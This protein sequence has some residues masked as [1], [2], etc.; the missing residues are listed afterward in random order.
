MSDFMLTGR[1][2][3][4]QAKATA[5]DFR[6]GRLS[7]REFFATMAAF[8]VS[9]AG[10]YAL[11]GIRPAAAQDATPVKGGTLRV[12][13]L[14]KA[15]R[16]P[17]IFE[18]TE[19]ANIA[20][21]CNDYLVRW[22]NDFSFAPQLLESWEASDDAMTYTFNVRKGVKWSNGD[23]F[24]A[25]DVIFNLTRW[26]DPSVEGNSFVARLAA[27]MDA[28]GKTLLP[29]A[30]ERV[31]DHTVRLNLRQPDIALIANLS[32]YPALIMHRS[33]DGSDDPMQAL[34][35]GTG[36]FE[37]VSFETGMRAEVR[38]RAQPWWGG[39]V[40][41]DGVVWTDYGTDSTAMVS[42]FAAGEI[43]A[44]YQT[45]PDFLPLVEAAGI[46]TEGAATAQT[47]VLRLNQGVA[48]YDDVR[49]RRAMQLAV[50][51]QKVLELGYGNAGTVAANHHV[52][53]MHE[54]YAD[55]GPA[56]TDGQEA[57]ALMEAAGQADHEFDLISQEEE[58]QSNS[59]DAV[60]DQMRAAGLKVKRTRIPGATFWN[61]WDKYPFSATEWAGRPLGVQVYM[62]AYKST[63]PWSETAFSNA[64]FDALLDE[65]TAI[66]DARKRSEVMAKLQWIMIDEGVILQPYWRS[67]YRS[68]SP[69]VRGLGAHQAFR[70]FMDRVWLTT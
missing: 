31:D 14:V 45:T 68:F 13:M 34:A 30:I 57:A 20:A 60:A 7:R 24:T 44:N 2:L 67:V 25:D 40:H 4:P 47:L 42:A 66:A 56:V 69:R 18:W 22:D 36:P 59:C 16:D 41:L 17:R 64:E 12:A 3:H 70:Q 28:D 55:I 53:P 23:D 51:N 50:D 15:F 54:D 6:T 10:A 26:A 62:L 8:G 11:G 58:W 37:L 9:A 27:L 1:S 32:D 65:A 48:P 29:N 43:D 35:I 49:V 39:D 63:G 33:Y 46:I 5:E 38:R 21:C 61:D 52:G 19:P